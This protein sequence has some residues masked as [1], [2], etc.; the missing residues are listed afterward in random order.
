MKIAYFANPCDNHDCKWINKF[1]ESH[2]VYL[3]CS[4]INSSRKVFIKDDSIP[5]YPILPNIFPYKN[6]IKYYSIKQKIL[7]FLTENKIQIIHSMYAYPNSLYPYIVGFKNHII[8]TRGS[9]ILK[10]YSITFKSPNNLKE[11]VIYSYLR[12][13]MEQS[14]KQASFITS[15]SYLQ[16]EVIAQIINDKEKSLVVRTG[17]DTDLLKRFQKKKN[18]RQNGKL[19]VFSPRSMKPIY[20]IELILEGFYLIKNQYNRNNFELVLIDDFPESEY[21][22]F[23]KDEIKRLKL[24]ED[25]TLL[26][27]QTLEQMVENY[28]QCD[29]AVM[30][31]K[32][33]GTPNTAL[34]AMFL[35]RPVIIG[36]LTYDTDI[37]NEKTIWKL[38]ENSPQEFA[39]VLIKWWNNDKVQIKEKVENAF[40]AVCSSASLYSSLI[41]VEKLYQKMGG[42]N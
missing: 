16:K 29:I 25:V 31:P 2:Q 18:K 33:D 28:I 30:M 34:E 3:V 21:S 37:F 36:D 38:N 8:T 12:S 39:S 5:I 9:D 40:E 27:W 42:N 13:L 14:L 11:K 6:P 4:S 26:K 15:T 20:N 19:V 1:A 23:I 32:S 35:R 41:Q 10:D 22:N 7:N 17:I 24:E